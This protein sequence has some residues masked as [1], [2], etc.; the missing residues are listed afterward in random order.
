M[1]VRCRSSMCIVSSLRMRMY[2]R[3]W[4][5]WMVGGLRPVLVIGGEGKIIGGE[6]GGEN[7]L[8]FFGICLG[9]QMAVIEYAR[10]ILGLKDAH[11]TEMD[12]NTSDAVFNMMEQQKKTTIKGG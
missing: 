9:M 3:A 12:V 5:F 4:A 7:K 6:Y 2:A 8:P 11:S 1:N 10:N